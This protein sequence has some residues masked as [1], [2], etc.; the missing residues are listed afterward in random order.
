MTAHHSWAARVL[1]AASDERVRLWTLYRARV[2]D[3]P[4]DHDTALKSLIEQL[5]K[6]ETR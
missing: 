1:A 6:E 2:T 4:E 5:D 3:A